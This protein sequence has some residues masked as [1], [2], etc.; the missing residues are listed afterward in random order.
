MGPIIRTI[1]GEERPA[2]RFYGDGSFDCPWCNAPVITPRTTCENPGCESSPYWTAAALDAY[3]AKIRAEEEDR[4]YRVRSLAA[5]DERLR[6]EKEETAA[7]RSDCIVQAR[8]KGACLDCLF[9]PGWRRV[10]FIRHRGP[11]PKG[12]GR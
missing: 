5:A 4:A 1:L 3:R 2:T 9:Q 10:K 12:R 8:A 11:C 7:W 6:R